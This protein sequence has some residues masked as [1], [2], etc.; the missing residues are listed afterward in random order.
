M[1]VLPVFPEGHEDLYE[2]LPKV[3]IF[4]KKQNRGSIPTL[5]LLQWAIETMVIFEDNPYVFEYDLESKR[6][7]EE[8]IYE[9]IPRLR[10]FLFATEDST[11]VKQELTLQLIQQQHQVAEDLLRRAMQLNKLLA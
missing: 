1:N 7:L 2:Y 6:R 9:R 10:K 11:M 3:G 8:C 5:A 4:S